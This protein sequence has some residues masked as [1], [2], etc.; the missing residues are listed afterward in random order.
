M[1]DITGIKITVD[2]GSNFGTKTIFVTD[3]NITY[4][5][6]KVKVLPLYTDNQ[7]YWLRVQVMNFINDNIHF[8]GTTTRNGATVKVEAVTDDQF[9]EK[10]VFCTKLFTDLQKRISSF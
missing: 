6:N 4:D 7:D 5:D 3:S 1:K 2:Y 9:R 10:S 8:P